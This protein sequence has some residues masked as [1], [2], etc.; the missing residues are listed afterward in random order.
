[1]NSELLNQVIKKLIDHNIP[2]PRLEAKMLITYA[3]NQSQNIWDLL[4]QR[5][6]HTPLDKIMGTKGFYKND[7]IVD[8]NV[9]SPRPDTEVL[10][11]KAIDIIKQNDLK[12]ALDLGTGSG[13]IIL[14]VLGDCPNIKATA[15]DKSQKAL[16]IA[17]QNAKNLRLADKVS[18]KELDWFSDKIEGSFDIILSNPPYIP[19]KDIQTLEPEVK[20]HD[21]LLALDGGDDGLNSYKKIASISPLIL[22]DKGFILLE[23]GI[24]QAKDVANIFTNQGLTLISIIKDL[25]NIERCLVFQK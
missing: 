22:N 24:N 21:P 16:S 8:K 1:M 14:S 23:I 10:V 4:E 7:F 5:T 17:K 19:S 20:L 18:F 25:S 12:T 6:N 13:A 9:L 15:I 2:S 11:E 3:K